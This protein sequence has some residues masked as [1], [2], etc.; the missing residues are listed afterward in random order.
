MKINK[1]FDGISSKGVSIISFY[2]NTC[3]K[4]KMQHKVFETVDS[5]VEVYLVNVEEASDLAQKFNVL[6]LP[7]NI[8][9]KE[10]SEYCRYGFLPVTV[11]KELV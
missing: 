10:G 11:I 8:V 1:S 6:E 4:C 5:D 2:S 7:Y 9:L 3:P